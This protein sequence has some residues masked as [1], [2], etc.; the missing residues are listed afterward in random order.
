M[1]PITIAA[2]IAAGGTIGAG[3]LGKKANEEAMKMQ[4][5]VANANMKMQYDFARSGL[6]WK[7]EDA[8][9]AGI[10]PVYALGASSNMPSPVSVGVSPDNSMADMAAGLGQNISRAVA[11]GGTREERALKELQLA[12]AKADLDGKIIDNS[13]RASQLRQLQNVP[14]GISSSNF[15]PG[16][17]NGPLVVDEPTKRNVSEPGRPAQEAGWRPDVSYSRTDTGLTP[18]IPQGLSESMEDDMIGK[19]MWRIR[20][21]VIPNF[22]G[23]GKPP[24]S[25]LPKGYDDWDWSFTQQEWQPVKGR[26]SYP[27]KKWSDSVSDWQNDSGDSK[28]GRRPWR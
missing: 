1:D 6:R 10:H 3:F 9:A 17:G 19:I 7:M 27:W 23:G 5:D 8:R 12:G 14:P 11:A 18:V 28:F 26:G 24:L 15:M 4:K 21:Q 2:L 20:N 25:Q 16:Q 22:S 13:I